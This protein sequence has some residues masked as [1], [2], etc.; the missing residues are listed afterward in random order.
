LKKYTGFGIEQVQSDFTHVA[1]NSQEV[2][3]KKCSINIAKMGK[4]LYIF[5]YK[6][7]IITTLYQNIKNCV[8]KHKQIID[9]FKIF[10]MYYKIKKVLKLYLNILS[11]INSKFKI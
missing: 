10:E 3:K 6:L 2:K 5:F 4:I 7:K 9:F 1:G 11:W 8:H